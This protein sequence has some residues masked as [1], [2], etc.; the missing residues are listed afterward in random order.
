VHGGSIRGGSIRGGGGSSSSGGGSSSSGGGTSSSTSGGNG[1]TV[2]NRTEVRWYLD[3]LGKLERY[4]RQIY[5][6]AL[7]PYSPQLWIGDSA[8]CHRPSPLQFRR[9][10]RTLGLP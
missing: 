7:T 10:R 3:R 9:R 2:I 8:R 1:R 4:R 5:A 6:L